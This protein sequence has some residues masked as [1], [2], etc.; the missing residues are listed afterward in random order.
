MKLAETIISLFDEGT[1]SLQ[2]D[3]IR[4]ERNRF[5]FMIE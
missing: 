2:D 5:I 3:R 4:Y 1:S